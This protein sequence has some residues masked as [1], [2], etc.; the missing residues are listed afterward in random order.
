MPVLFSLVATECDVV[1]PKP[2]YFQPLFYNPVRS[3]ELICYR[4][5]YDNRFSI[6]CA[7]EQVHRANAAMGSLAAA[8]A[9]TYSVYI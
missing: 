1:Y 3:A 6:L 9:E 7:V 2:N 8:A 4:P 5:T